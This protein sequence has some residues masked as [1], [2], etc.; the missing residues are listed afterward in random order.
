MCVVTSCE[1]NS[2]KPPLLYN[3]PC[4]KVMPTPDS[5]KYFA[6]YDK[7]II[8]SPVNPNSLIFYSD[9]RVE[10]EWE[11]PKGLW[12]SEL[13]IIEL[14]K[15]YECFD[16]EKFHLLNNLPSVG[17]GNQFIHYHQLSQY[18]GPIIDS[19]FV[20]YRIRTADIGN[21]QKYSLWTDVRTFA[22]APLLNLKKEVI[23]VSYNFNFTTEE[24]NEFYYSSVLKMD[25]YKLFEI[26]NENNLNFD[27]IQ[28]IRPVKF[29]TNFVTKYETNRNPFSRIMIGFDE[30]FE[31]N[32]EFYPFEVFADVYPG[33]Y[34]ESPVSGTLYSTNTGNFLSEMNDYDLKVAYKLEDVPGKQHQIIID[35]TYEV[36]SD[37]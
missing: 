33:S 26:S 29:E 12:N 17:Y 35:L 16:Y 7:P 25:N 20:A 13:Q 11:L 36:F 19:V 32:K 37:Y 2:D 30:D 10:I 9:E 31:Y 28:F 1:D 5:L 18:N 34:E 21:P 27:K 14:D 15:P 23:T 24:S 4:E 6:V 22:I 3:D 8:Y